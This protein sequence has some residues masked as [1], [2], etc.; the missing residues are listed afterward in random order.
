MKYFEILPT[1]DHRFDPVKFSLFFQRLPD[2][3]DYWYRFVLMIDNGFGTMYVGCPPDEGAVVS[4][5]SALK[6][7]CPEVEA[8][9]VDGIPTADWP[10]EWAA[11]LCP[12][13][14]IL[15]VR[16]APEPVFET[17]ARALGLG[18]INGARGVL[19]VYFDPL[20]NKKEQSLHNKATRKVGELLGI[21]LNKGSL[22][23]RLERELGPQSLSFGGF[24]L[25]GKKP[26]RQALPRQPQAGPEQKDLA[27]A[28]KERFAQKDRLFRT[29][30]RC[31]IHSKNPQRTKS[32]LAT[33]ANV[34]SRSFS[35]HNLIVPRTKHGAAKR[36][37]S[38]VL[39]FW[40]GNVLTAKELAQLV[41]IPS[42]DSPSGRHIKM[43]AARTAAPP[44]EMLDFGMPPERMVGPGEE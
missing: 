22:L 2:V 24:S 11:E 8:E 23:E 29:L 43:T 44:P 20:N 38:G 13:S 33:A 40:E 10:S 31:S 7:A 12:A 21:Q 19:D 28:I 41:V 36:L 16:I 39:S 35:W 4:F 1:H 34:I 42:A 6:T 27:Y 18:H 37:R 5:L 15:P 26:S 32:M 25:A 3:K 30:I 14:D 17:A 9:P